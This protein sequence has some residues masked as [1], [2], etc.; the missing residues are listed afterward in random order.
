MRI[1]VGEYVSG[2]GLADQAIDEIPSSLRREGTAMLQAIVS[3]LSE[4]AETVVPLDPRFAS[5]FSS[6][7]ADT[8]NM[9]R[10]QSLWGQWVTAAQTCDAALLVAPESNGI[11][12]KAVAMLRG[13]GVDVIAGSGDFLRT[14]S[15]KYLT[16][17]ILH[18]AGVSHP[19]YMTLTDRRMEETL[20]QY[21]QFVVKPRDGCGTQEIR[22]YDS[23]AK[24]STDLTEDGI[25]QAWIPGRAISIALVASATQHTFLPAVSQDLSGS[26]CEY[27]GGTGPLDDDAQ[28]RAT[29]LA[30]RAIVAMP[31]T[32]RGFV[33][34]DLLLGERPS[35]DCVIEINPRLTTSYV[36]LRRMIHGNLAARLFDM[37]T[38]AV[39]CCT[40]ANSVRW[41]PNGDVWIN[42]NITESA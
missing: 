39:S 4:V 23:L 17:K 40:A 24:A 20:H 1:F 5:A 19:P 25:L 18:T 28:R 38:G 11:L 12:A 34:L 15:D 30:S 32:A 9:D 16:A 26:H 10:D 41:T 36:G 8:V 6:N 29:A 2:G 14:A 3:D 22:I 42:D 33:G 21:E 37:E 27:G 13:S 31:P 7:T 35:E